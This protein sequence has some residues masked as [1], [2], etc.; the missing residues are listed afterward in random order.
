MGNDKEL[1]ESLL[2]YIFGGILLW[3]LVVVAINVAII[4]IVVHFVAKYW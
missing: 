2:R 3:G 4:C 1:G